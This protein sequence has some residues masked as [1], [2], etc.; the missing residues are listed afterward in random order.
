MVLIDG[1]LV[2]SSSTIK[3]EQYLRNVLQTLRDHLLNVKLSEYEIWLK[4]VIFLGHIILAEGIWVDPRKVEVILNWKRPSNVIEIYSFF[5]RL[6]GFYRRFI[7][8][9]ST[10]VT[11]LTLL[12]RKE[13]KFEWSK[14]YEESL[15]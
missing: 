2:Y 6:V 4:D 7:E 14:E 3:H 13:V 8:G 10:I 9:S 5:F 1:I 11:S 15:Q 12:A